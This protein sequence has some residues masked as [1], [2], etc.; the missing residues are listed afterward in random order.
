MDAARE[1]GADGEHHR[2]GVEAQA[3]LGDDAGDP[4]A[5]HDQVVHALL[6]EL[7]VGLGVQQRAH[8]PLV[9]LPVGL[10]AGGPDGRALAGVEGAE[11]DAGPVGRRGHEAAQRV[12]LLRQVAL[13]DAA[14]GRV[15]AHL[16][17]G[18]QVLGE[19]QRAGAQARRG[20]GGLGAGVAAADH[21]HVP[22]VGAA[23]I[24]GILKG[25]RS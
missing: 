8:G 3:G 22:G 7:Q 15:A 21:D 13:A 17:D 14:D 16:A 9:E 20:R 19:Q 10:G 18:F 24:A 1:E 5:L 4:V 23:H 12:D 25:R 2:P 6:E 11:V